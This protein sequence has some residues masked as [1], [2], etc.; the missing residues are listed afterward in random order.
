MSWRA[1]AEYITFS[2]AATPSKCVSDAPFNLHCDFETNNIST[3]VRKITTSLTKKN[4]KMSFSQGQGF[5]SYNSR[6]VVQSAVENDVNDV[7]DGLRGH[8]ALLGSLVVSG[9]DPPAQLCLVPVVSA[10]PSAAL[11]EQPGAAAQPPSVS[12]GCSTEDTGGQALLLCLGQ[13]GSSSLLRWRYNTRH[14]GIHF[15]SSLAT[16]SS[17]TNNTKFFFFKPCAFGCLVLCSLYSACK[18]NKGFK[19]LTISYLACVGV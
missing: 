13:E 18:R 5:H 12:R 7:E 9:G 15:L 3:N 17:N 19:I 4:K 1:A 11:P 8:A 14:F 10:A 16:K 6:D 2:S